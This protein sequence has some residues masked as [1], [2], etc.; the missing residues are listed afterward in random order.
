M[1]IEKE[2]QKLKEKVTPLSAGKFIMGTLVSLGT[3]AAVIA[4]LRNPL[5]GAKG[6]TKLLMRLGIFV[7]G[8]KAGDV[9]EEYF[10]KSVDDL[11]N[12]FKEDK[13]EPVAEQ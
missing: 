9:A 11:I 10:N 2:I 5:Q 4:A 7:I 3:T 6:L 8:C 13:D 12:A 1:D